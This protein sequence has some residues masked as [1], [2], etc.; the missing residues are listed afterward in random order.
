MAFDTIYAAQEYAADTETELSNEITGPDKKTV[1]LVTIDDEEESLTIASPDL[2]VDEVEEIE[3]LNETIEVPEDREDE[4]IEKPRSS[5]RKKN[6]STVPVVPF[7]SQFTDISAPAWKKVGCG[8][9]SLAMLISY[10][11]EEVAVDDLLTKGISNGAYLDSA[12]WTH[13]GLIKL[14]NDYGLDGSS[15]L[16]EYLH[17]DDAFAKLQ[18]AL[19]GG[20]VMASVHYTFEPT[21]PIPHLVIINGVRDGQVFY[22]DPAETSGGKSLSIGK[23]KSGWKK[24]FIEIRPTT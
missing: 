6:S 9:A 11:G 23:F 18:L 17:V 5:V 20:P 21:N 24:R 1:R 7:Y 16:L 4:V 22:N 3:I 12:G 13:A 8:V 2:E 14:S 15:T 10:Y 19:K